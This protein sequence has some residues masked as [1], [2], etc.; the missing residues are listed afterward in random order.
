MHVWTFWG[1]Q[2][3]CHSIAIEVPLFEDVILAFMNRIMTNCNIT[4]PLTCLDISKKKKKKKMTHVH[5][6]VFTLSICGSFL[7]SW[8]SVQFPK[9]KVYRWIV[10]QC[11]KIWPIWCP[12][13]ILYVEYTSYMLFF[14]CSILSLGYYY[15]CENQHMVK[16]IHTSM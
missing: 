4:H 12:C 13:N 7:F 10:L 2:I 1:W 6:F 9:W 14:I 3:S 16:F 5:T 11:I 15:L 8:C